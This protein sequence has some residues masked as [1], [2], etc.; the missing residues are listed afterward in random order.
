MASVDT[1]ETAVV[2]KSRSFGAE[3][4]KFISSPQCPASDI[5][6]STKKARTLQGSG[7]K[8]SCETEN[9]SVNDSAGSK[10]N[11]IYR[12]VLRNIANSP[13]TKPKGTSSG[14]N[15]HRGFQ[16]AK[17]KNLLLK[18]VSVAQKQAVGSDFSS[19]SSHNRSSQHLNGFNAHS[20]VD[21]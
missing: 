8:L 3:F 2:Q 1:N 16:D 4:R 12:A 15:S 20:L 17:S 6:A 13:K 18:N 19:G 9:A 11:Q 14:A 7:V 21:H 10:Q 5:S